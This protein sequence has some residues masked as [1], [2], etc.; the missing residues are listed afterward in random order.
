MKKLI[1]LFLLIGLVSARPTI[2]E[3]LS[4]C[5]TVNGY[6]YL[7]LSAYGQEVGATGNS[8]EWVASD[9]L[10]FSSVGVSF[11]AVSAGG[12]PT[13]ISAQAIYPNG[14]AVTGAQ[15]ITDGTDLTVLYSGDYKFTF[16]NWVATRDVTFNFVIAD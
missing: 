12:L 3:N 11:T 9:I 8:I 14:V 13:T 6:Q 16:Y 7:Q 2:Q 1:L 10:G 15:T 5:K 4:D